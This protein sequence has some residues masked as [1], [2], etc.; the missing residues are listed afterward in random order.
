MEE[1]GLEVTQL[2]VAVL[3]LITSLIMAGLKM[4][5]TWFA[6]L[7]KTSQAMMVGALAIPIGLLGGVM[8]VD[9]PG[10]PTTWDGNTVNVILT[11]LSSMGV[12]ALGDAVKK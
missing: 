1:L 4:G 11:W 5:I 6:K 10:D 8:G 9:L 2:L 7:P 12:H 3:G